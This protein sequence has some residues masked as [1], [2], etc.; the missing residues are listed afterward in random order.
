MIG[1][2]QDRRPMTTGETMRNRKGTR[3]HRAFKATLHVT[4]SL[5]T[6]TI[7]TLRMLLFSYSPLARVA[8]LNWDMWRGKANTPLS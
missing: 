1:L 6:N 3:M 2:Q 4:S 8:I 7:S 5:S